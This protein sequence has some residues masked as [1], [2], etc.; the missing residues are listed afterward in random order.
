M[1]EL[2]DRRKELVASLVKDAIYEAAIEI[3]KTHG[4]DGLTM[5]RVAETAGVAKGSLY[6]HFGNKNELIEFIY[7]KTVEPVRLVFDDVVEKNISAVEKLE[8]L[9]RNWFDYFTSNRG[10]FDFLFNNIRIIDVADTCKKSYRAEVIK[11]AATIFEQGIAE[12]TFRHVHTSRAA[13]MFVGAIITTSE[14][15]LH[16]NEQRPADESVRTILD[17]FLQGLEPR[18]A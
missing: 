6:N 2:A 17:L 7:V 12:G 8:I 13:E 16:S 1:S 15:E 14:Q 3:L 9:L 4:V 5:E 10:I 18:N 11:N